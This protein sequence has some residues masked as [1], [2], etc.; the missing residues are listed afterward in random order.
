MNESIRKLAQT[1][2]SESPREQ[3]ARDAA[4]LVRGSGNYRWVGIYDV[5][6]D[7]I[8]LIGHTG[9]SLPEHARFSADAGVSGEAVRTRRTVISITGSEAIVPILG[10]ETGIPI[11]T[12]DA[13]CDRVDAFTQKDVEF[14]EECASVLRPLYD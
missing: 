2:D 3:R 12:L 8:V 14:L 6:D 13:E 5:G 7:E 10:A 4:E 11:G 1:V 9:T